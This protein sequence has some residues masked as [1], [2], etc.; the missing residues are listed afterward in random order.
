MIVGSGLPLMAFMRSAPRV[1]P[2]PNDPLELAGGEVKVAGPADRKALL[3]LLARARNGYA[4]RRSGLGYDLKV[5]FTVDTQGQT[6]DDGAWELEDLF[7]PG[8]GLRWTAQSAT[9]YAVTG[10][11]SNGELYGDA[12][13]SAIPLRVEEVRGILLHP[14]P[15]AAYASRES[16]RMSTATFHGAEVTCVLLSTSK[17]PVYPAA[18]RAWEESEECIDQKSG[19]LLMHSEAPG[20]YVVYDYS[21]ASRLGKQTLP[22]TVTVTEAGRVVSK[23][24]VEKLEEWNAADPALFVPTKAM[25]ARGRFIEM[26]AST[27]IQRVHGKGPFTSAM[28]VRPV[29]VFGMVTPAGQ[30]V[31]AH[32]LQPSDPNSQAAVADAEQIDFSPAAAGA[33]PGASLAAPLRQ[34]FVFVIEKFISQ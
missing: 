5:S 15:S 34:H 10:I 31:D 30:L 21:N 24:S 14:L 33:A 13:A 28:T 1:A 23:I 17:K 3:D 18:G 6:D 29:C 26:T 11:A 9:G 25:M 16:I 4:L 2:V 12:M 32:S 20:R 7:V 22:G 19:L 27:K 8:R